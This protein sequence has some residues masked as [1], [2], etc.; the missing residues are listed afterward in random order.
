MTPLVARLHTAATVVR[1]CMLSTGRR[2]CG[3]LL[4]FENTNLLVRL[5]AINAGAGRGAGP[6]RRPCR[7]AGSRGAAGSQCHCGLEPYRR[8]GSMLASR[9]FF[10]CELGSPKRPNPVEKLCHHWWVWLSTIIVCICNAKYVKDAATAA[11]AACSLPLPTAILH[12][13]S[14][15]WLQLM[16]TTAKPH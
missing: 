12:S 14:L 13:L 5:G 8:L 16:L 7:P 4:P 2:S 15:P 3:P 1:A 10:G 11:A 6:A 9:P